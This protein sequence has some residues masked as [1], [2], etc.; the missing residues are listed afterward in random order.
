M[1]LKRVWTAICIYVLFVIFDVTMVASS[2]FFSGLFPSDNALLYTGVFTA[3]SA[4]I[5]GVVMFVAGKISDNIDTKE[6][7]DTFFTKLIYFLMLITILFGSVIYRSDVLSIT[8]AAPNGKLSLYENAKVG[9]FTVNS[10]QDLLSIL[11]SKLLNMVLIFTGNRITFALFFQ[12]ALFVLFILCAVIVARLLLGK[13]ASVIVGAYLSFMPVFSD[14]LRNVRVDTDD[15]FY[16]LF[17]LELLILAI[18]LKTDSDGAYNKKVFVYGLWFLCVGAV[19]GFMTY[20]DAGTLIVI[21]PL[22]LAGLFIVKNS[23]ASEIFRLLFILVGGLTAFFGMIFQEGGANGF[24]QVLYNWSHYFFKNINTFNT[25]WTYTNYKIEYLATFVAMTGIIVGFWRNRRYEKVTPW[26]LSTMIVFF[27]TP[28]FGATRTNSETMLTVFFGFV[29]GAVVSLITME[30]H[31]NALLSEIEEYEDEEDTSAEAPEQAPY[32]E[33]L[34]VKPETMPEK[35]LV[36][37]MAEKESSDA[38]N[39]IKDSVADAEKETAA[40]PDEIEENEGDAD[41]KAADAQDVIEENEGDAGKETAVTDNIEIAESEEYYDSDDE[42]DVIDDSGNEVELSNDSIENRDNADSESE[43]DEFVVDSESQPQN[44]VDSEEISNKNSAFDGYAARFVPEGMVLPMGAEDEMDL[45]QSHMKMPE[46]K[47]TIGL[48]RGKE[49]EQTPSEIAQP[50]QEVVHEEFP[51]NTQDRVQEEIHKQPRNKV[52][53][54]AK[55]VA[56]SEPQ[57]TAASVATEPERKPVDKVDDILER[58]LAEKLAKEKEKIAA[59]NKSAEPV[60]PQPKPA[61]PAKKYQYEFDIAL[62]PGDDF[63]IK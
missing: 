41:K 4:V 47:G 13:A 58:L 26:L 55:E 18:Y 22:L 17:G 10:E 23:V 56:S 48:N 9:T 19:I 46:F 38:E 43:A 57:N 1:K 31:E 3:L 39:E 60:K 20:V 63:D 16:L 37:A 14:G 40:E 29:L 42:D 62:K 28:F 61:T 21:L 27:V 54:E 34:V 5:M 8:T 33:H 30:S 24:D 45:S 44:V 52:H 12:L 51:E 49:P 15:L 36:P 7:A 53:E 25:F 32:P 59:S 11:Y 2:G 35:P 50:V 6:L